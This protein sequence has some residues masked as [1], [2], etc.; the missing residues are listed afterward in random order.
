MKLTPILIICTAAE[1]KVPP[2]HPQQRLRT[3]LRFADEWLDDNFRA[4][5]EE[6]EKG[7]NS[8]VRLADRFARTFQNWGGRLKEAIDR[9]CFYYDENSPHGGKTKRS[10]DDGNSGT[11][12]DAAEYDTS[13]AADD[14]LR[15]NK[16]NPVLGLRQITTGFRKWSM[17]YISDCAGERNDQKHSGR[18][19]RLNTKIG[20]ELARFLEKIDETI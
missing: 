15:Y 3:L 16:S 8:G 18:A 19:K 1:K 10:V 14:L 12:L 2:R 20:E 5:R 9:K 17:R 4:R 6:D 11:N 13:K 7:Y